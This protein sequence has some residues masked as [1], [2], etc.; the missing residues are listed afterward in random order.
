[1][2]AKTTDHSKTA[3][4]GAREEGGY[5]APRVYRWSADGAQKVSLFRGEPCE[6]KEAAVD[7]AC[8]WA[9][10]NGIDADQE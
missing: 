2:N 1:M 4:Y 6:T 8:Q 3:Y 5:W 10:A 7:A 9:E